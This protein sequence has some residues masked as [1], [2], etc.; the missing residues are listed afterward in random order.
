MLFHE[1]RF[2]KIKW[3]SLFGLW[4]L[5]G[6]FAFWQLFTLASD[7]GNFVFGLSLPRFVINLFLFLWVAI[8]F[9]LILLVSG[10]N[11]SWIK[12]KNVL[13]RSKTRD[14][15]LITAS[16]L[17]FLIVY[18]GIFRGLLDAQLITQYGAYIDRLFPLLNL[19][20]YISFEII[21]LISYVN[22]YNTVN[23][24]NVFFSFLIKLIFVIF[25]LGLLAVVIS[26][27]GLGVTTTYKGDWGH[28]KAAVP[29]LEWQIL[30]ACLLCLGMIFF[31]SK[32]K[33]MEFPR[34][35]L[36]ICIFIWFGTCIFWLSQPVIPSASALGPREPNFEIYPFIDSQNYDEF[37]QSILIGEGFGSNLIPLRPLYIV[38]LA[39]LHIL[40]GQSYEQMI[41]AQ[42][43]FFAIFPVLLYIFGREFIGRPIG[44]SIAL[45]A[46]LRDYT[47]NLVSPFTGNLSYSKVYL[48]EI[49]TAI[50][51]VLFL[52]I[53]IRWI[54]S[55]FPAFLG[56]L[57]GGI[58]GVAML[59]RTQA[60]VAL[61][62]VILFA[63]LIRPKN[64]KPLIKS[65][66]F[67]FISLMLV[68][69]PWL[70]R[71]WLLTGELIFDSP[72]FQT[73]NLALR[74]SRLNGYESDIM[75]F[76]N[77]SN[78]D[79][80]ERLIQMARDAIS[81]DPQKAVWG[82]SNSFLN[83]GVNNILLFPLRNE[84]QSFN[85]LYIPSDAFW[86]KWDGTPTT[87]QAILLVFYICLFGLGVT[88][89][90]YRNGLL[91]LMPLML[92][93][94]YNLWTSLAL[95]SGQRFMVTMDWSIYL[96]YVIGLFA[97]LG[98]FLFL[99]NHSRTIIVAWVKSN[100]FSVEASPIKVKWGG[101]LIFG[102]LLLGIGSSLPLSEKIFPDKY[103][104]RSQEEM[105][106][107]L[108][109]SP[110]LNQSEL[111]CL[112]ILAANDKLTFAQGM[113]V[114]PRYYGAGEGESITDKIGY[115]PVD[116]G[117]L[118]FDIIRGSRYRIVFP[119]AKSP[120][121][122]PHASDVT[123]IYNEIGE[124]WFILVKQENAGNFYIS[125][126]FESSSCQIP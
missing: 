110:S 15:V 2:R 81:V 63:F 78:A 20:A 112:Q 43:L 98:G 24:K 85:D 31:E 89:A 16:P 54:K 118:V 105:A 30:L 8:N 76:S 96:Y 52:Y 40:V 111:A 125:E 84:L 53:G 22:L 4:A 47:S 93:L 14:I 42:T 86:E 61:P 70:W 115:K 13:I 75:R 117:R 114:Y 116:E 99:L 68:I 38:F 23:D 59:I 91:G 12:L 28:G 92:N 82:I 39:F 123:L 67:I 32:K 17:F 9:L 74:Y 36:L 48:S 26:L 106:L 83:H 60:V 71:N 49:P 7:G 65:M 79:Y 88:I 102:A 50:F 35:D 5:H 121:F 94:F 34:L 25:V 120:E 126:S 97:L 69:S 73:A 103:P 3:M 6:V 41:L 58:L 119:L 1:D 72:E 108:M 51:L 100:P 101:Y 87:S 18:F 66:L 21:I 109:M 107:E 64:I 29:L 45:L 57:L 56:F 10:N 19:I 77:E 37:A 62:V 11:E 55:G 46:V 27:T 95:L 122:F 90:W 124:L 33:S 113:A 80:N 44:I 104:P